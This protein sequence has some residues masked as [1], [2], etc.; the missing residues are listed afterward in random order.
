MHQG[1]STLVVRYGMSP[2]PTSAGD[3][4]SS[5]AR[6]RF[7][8]SSNTRMLF[9]TLKS[10]STLR[11][12]AHLL[13]YE[14]CNCDFAVIAWAG[15]HACKAISVI[16]EREFLETRQRSHDFHEIT[17]PA[18]VQPLHTSTHATVLEFKPR[19]PGASCD[20]VIDSL[21]NTCANSQINF[22]AIITAFHVN[23]QTSY[24]AGHACS[25]AD[26]AVNV[27]NAVRVNEAVRRRV[28]PA[29]ITQIKHWRVATGRN[30][31]R[32]SFVH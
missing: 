20:T 13:R 7:R 27:N 1:I 24:V 23:G 2:M 17:F 31:A 12:P 29:K 16:V 14:R 6:K 8:S 28:A 5:K 19:I 30:F 15:S 10:G 22:S 11:R 9:P 32:S 3:G 18:R 4:P 25:A 21:K 26:A